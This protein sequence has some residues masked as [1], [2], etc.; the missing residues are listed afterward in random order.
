[1]RAAAAL[2]TVSRPGFVRGT[3][4]LVYGHGVDVM[5]IYGRECGREYLTHTTHYN[6]ERRPLARR[7]HR[8]VRLYYV[9]TI[10]QRDAGM[11]IAWA[12]P[13]ADVVW[14]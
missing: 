12:H 11:H 9:I 5:M 8:L 10:T 2:P 7:P 14:A 4:C 13:A 6:Q 3:A 1:M